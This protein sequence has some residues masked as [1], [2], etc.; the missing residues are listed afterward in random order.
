[1]IF[2]FSFCDRHILIVAIWLLMY[3]RYI[4]RI[5]EA[6]RRHMGMSAA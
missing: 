5:A 1:M 3:T 2:F 4:S 6:N